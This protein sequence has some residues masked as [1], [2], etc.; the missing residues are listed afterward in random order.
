MD[1]KFV[2]VASGRTRKGYGRDSAAGQK[3]TLTGRYTP[4][5]ATAVQARED[6]SELGT[7]H[8]CSASF[9]LAVSDAALNAHMT[10]EGCR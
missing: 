6:A 3:G 5:D 2:L 7:S 9:N 8:L 4:L 10:T 1:F